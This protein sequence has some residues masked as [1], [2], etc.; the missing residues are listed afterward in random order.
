MFEWIVMYFVYFSKMSSFKFTFCVIAALLTIVAVV[1]SQSRLKLTIISKFIFN[2]Q[3]RLQLTIFTSNSQTKCKLTF[4]DEGPSWSSSH[5]SW[6]Y[7]YL[8]NQ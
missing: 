1:N 8:C 4:H 6:I 7:N 3:I 2:C 5:G